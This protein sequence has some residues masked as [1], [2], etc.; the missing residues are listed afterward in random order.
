MQAYTH[1]N[2]LRAAFSGFSFMAIYGAQLNVFRR[3]IKEKPQ[4]PISAKLA[5]RSAETLLDKDGKKRYPH[6]PKRTVLA[7]G[8]I[9]W[10]GT[11]QELCDEIE[12]TEKHPRARL[13]REEVVLL[14]DEMD[15]QARLDLT[16][17]IAESIHERFKVAVDFA[18]H[19][20][21]K[22]NKN[23]HTHITFTTRECLDGSTL[24]KKTAYLDNQ[25]TSG[26]HV[27]W[28]RQMVERTINS[29]MRSH[30]KTTL[31]PQ[32]LTVDSRS[33]KDR[34]IDRTPIPKLSPAEY[35][36]W[37]KKGDIISDRVITYINAVNEKKAYDERERTERAFE[38]HGIEESIDPEIGIKE[39]DN[40]RLESASADIPGTERRAPEGEQR[41]ER[42]HRNIRQR[43]REIKQNCR[44]IAETFEGI[45][46]SAEQFLRQLDRNR[47]DLVFEIFH[48]QSRARDDLQQQTNIDDKRRAC[49]LRDASEGSIIATRMQ[50]IELAHAERDR[51]YQEVEDIDEIIDQFRDAPQKPKIRRRT[52]FDDLEDLDRGRGGISM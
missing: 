40:Q 49:G 18:I 9:G 30:H 34:G 19:T 27:N 17:D 3:S 10:N 36:A 29:H 31:L 12:R 28:I 39:S 44:K 51:Q 2:L 1:P 5:Y 35:Y 33:L 25:R 13:A 23:H 7:T 41:S 46:S 15:D 14:P 32:E 21:D 37:H 4:P 16:K 24:T 38:D 11:R 48:N 22:D 26:P 42:G 52:A 43:I 45:R 20:P 50:T 47:R 8:F 6:R